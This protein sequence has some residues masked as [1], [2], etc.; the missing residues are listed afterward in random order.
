MAIGIRKTKMNIFLLFVAGMVV[1]VVLGLRQPVKET[2][3]ETQEYASV[4]K[5]NGIK[6]EEKEVVSNTA[7]VAK[8]AVK[9]AVQ[10]VKKTANKASEK[11]DEI[12]PGKTIAVPVEEIK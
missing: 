11:A 8:A 3:T 7:V 10:P 1:G 12:K 2:T 5:I 9:P 6:V 4:Q